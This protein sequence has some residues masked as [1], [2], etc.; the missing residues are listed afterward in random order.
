MKINILNQRFGR[1]LVIEEAPSKNNRAY[2]K[3]LCDCGN[4][5]II[6]GKDLRSGNTKSCGCLQKDKLRERS[7]KDLS[8]QKFGKLTALKTEKSEKNN[9]IW[10]CQCECGKL[11]EVRANSLLSGNTKSCG[12]LKKEVNAEKGINQI[13]DLTNKKFNFLLV[14]G[15]SKKKTHYGQYWLCKCDCGNEIEVLGTNLT[16]NRVLSCGCKKQSFGEYQI[17][18]L[19]KNQKLKYIKEYSFPDLRGDTFLLRFDFAVFNNLNELLY[20]IECDGEFHRNG[21]LQQER[22]DKM[23]DEYCKNKNIILKRIHY[24]H[25]DIITEI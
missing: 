8:N 4:E 15:K 19:L 5:K 23:K 9:R 10:L 21:N 1:L 2:W 7:S 3:C 14:I 25:G 11:V 20:L 18:E 13:I 6:C 12:C 24:N 22:Y 16:H 17:E